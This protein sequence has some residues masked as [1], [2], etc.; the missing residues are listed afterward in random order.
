MPPEGTV[1]GMGHRVPESVQLLAPLRQFHRPRASSACGA[2]LAGPG[3]ELTVC[4]S[5]SLPLSLALS[6]SR[7]LALSPSRSLSLSLSPSRS[8]SLSLSAHCLPFHTRSPAHAPAGIV[9]GSDS[10]LPAS[11]P[12]HSFPARWATWHRERRS[13]LRSAWALTALPYTLAARRSSPLSA[14]GC[15]P[16][17]NDAR[18]PALSWAARAQLGCARSVGLPP[19]AQLRRSSSSRRLER[20][21]A[22][23]E[24]IVSMRSR[25]W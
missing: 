4:V 9:Q 25:H 14:R 8:L 11:L 20:S 2:R 12:S 6:L 23:Y 3:S 15:C 16:L 13:G 17:V 10:P 24:H 22:S 18:R 21:L 19:L 7:S 1:S 5:F